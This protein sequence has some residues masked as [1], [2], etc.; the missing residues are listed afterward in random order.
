MKETIDTEGMDQI[1][2]GIEKTHKCSIKKSVQSQIIEKPDGSLEFTHGHR[3]L[4]V[5]IACADICNET[6]DVIMHLTTKNFNFDDVGFSLSKAGGD[7][8]MR[9]C[10][11]FG[12]PA[13]FSIHALH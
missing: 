11:A 3:N 7:S 10:I 4:K 12:Q 9:E 8:I 2:S 6:T 5:Q 13:P 1:F